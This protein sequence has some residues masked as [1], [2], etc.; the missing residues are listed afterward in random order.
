MP[1]KYLRKFLPS[2][3]TIREHR[4]M[5]K[6]GKWLHHPNLWHLNRH[7]VA[8]GVAV[9]MLTGLIPGSNP[10]QFTAAAVGSAMCKVNLPVAVLTTLYSNPFTIVP[11][12]YVAYKIGA[13]F[14]MVDTQA[15]P[16]T[17]LTLLDKP[18][19][20]WWPAIL[21]WLLGIGKTLGIGLPIL[22][23]ILAIVGYYAALW[24]WRLVVIWKWRRRGRNR[25]GHATS[26]P[27]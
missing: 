21:H 3:E 5:G 2:H 12:Y 8:G 10:V 14:T 11:L 25:A 6:L 16:A 1:R 15:M 22:G 26:S 4:I 7:S 18:L 20:Q 27:P 17:E 13:L 19:G 24:G 23:V 9:G